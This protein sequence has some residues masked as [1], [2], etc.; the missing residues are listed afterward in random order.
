MPKG[1]KCHVA[2]K[3]HYMWKKQTN[4]RNPKQNINPNKATFVHSLLHFS[5]KENVGVGTS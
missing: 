4:K 5:T 1:V 2:Q 3:H